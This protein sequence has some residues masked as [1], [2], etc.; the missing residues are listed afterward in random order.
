[1][2]VLA[3]RRGLGRLLEGLSN[4]RWGCRS[5]SFSGFIY[6]L[7]VLFGLGGLDILDDAGLLGVFADG[8]KVN[9]YL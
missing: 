6:F 7:V 1:M 5:L 9:L 2:G 3:R 4:G 8:L